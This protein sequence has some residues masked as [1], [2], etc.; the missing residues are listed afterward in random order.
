MHH[1][2]VHSGATWRIRWIIC[3]QLFKT[4]EPSQNDAD[5]VGCRLVRPKAQACIL[6]PPGEYNCIYYMRPEWLTIRHNDVIAVM[7]R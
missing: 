1:M 3:S 4:A 5:A 7:L 2:A 6:A